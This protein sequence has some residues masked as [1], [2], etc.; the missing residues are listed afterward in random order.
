[1]QAAAWSAGLVGLA[2]VEQHVIL[3]FDPTAKERGM[4]H[5]ME[6]PLHDEVRP[7]KQVFEIAIYAVSGSKRKP[8]RNRRAFGLK[9]TSWSTA[10]DCEQR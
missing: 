4:W 9:G 5:E 10:L 1:M 8:P 6:K 3:K 7:V 2:G